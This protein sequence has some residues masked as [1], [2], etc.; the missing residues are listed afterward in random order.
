[1]AQLAELLLNQ[2]ALANLIASD[3]VADANEENEREILSF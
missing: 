2:L 1:V 3:G